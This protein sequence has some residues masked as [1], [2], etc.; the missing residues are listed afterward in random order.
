MGI[1]DWLTTPRRSAAERYSGDVDAP[2]QRIPA[3][4][5][6]QRDFVRGSS[7]VSPAY[8]G[9]HFHEGPPTSAVY[10]CMHCGKVTGVNAGGTFDPA[11]EVMPTAWGVA[12]VKRAAERESAVN[13]TPRPPKRDMLRGVRVP[14]S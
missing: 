3:T 10:A 5:C 13:G 11:P 8:D 2:L 9:S 6:G 1:W 14:K 4:C 12:V 7:G